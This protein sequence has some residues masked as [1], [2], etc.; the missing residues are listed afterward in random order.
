MFKSIRSLFT[1]PV[2]EDDEDKTRVAYLL[3]ALLISLITGLILIGFITGF[4]RLTNYVLSLFITI[5][6]WSVMRSGHIRFASITIVAGLSILLTIVI[7]LTGGIRASTYGGFI[8]VIL[9]AG[10]VLGERSSI[11]VASFAS[12]LGGVLIG[13]ASYGIWEI[14]KS[15]AS[16]LTYWIVYTFYFFVS[17]V[18]LILASRLI[19]NSYRKIRVELI[20][21][22][23][24]E[25]EL[26]ILYDIAT[27]STSVDSL[28]EL[29]KQISNKIDRYINTDLFSVWL[30]DK[31]SQVL[32]VVSRYYHGSIPDW[33]PPSIPLRTGIIGIVASTG[34]AMRIP[35]VTKEP[36]YLDAYSEARSELCVPMCI[37]ERV[38]GVINMES[39]TLNA[40][41]EDNERLLVTIASQL[42]IATERFRTEEILKISEERLQQAVR[43]SNIGIFDHDHL[44]DTIYWS[45][46]QRRNYGWDDPEE[47]VVLDKFFNQ[48]Y[49][50]DRERIIT[51]VQKAHDPDGDGYFDVEHRITRKDGETRWLSTKS[52]TH[53]DG[54]GTD[55]HPYRTI[56]AVIDITENKKIE[57]EREMFIKELEDRNTD[58]ERF[59]YTV[60]HE[61]KSPIVTMKG[62]IGSVDSDLQHGN[63]ERAKKDLTRVS[64]AVDKMN[65]TLSG[66]LELTRI[67]HVVNPLTVISLSGLVESVLESI[68]EQI[69]SPDV[70]V[71]VNLDLPTIIGD[72]PRLQKVYENLIINAAKNMGN[73]TAPRIEIGFRQDD[74]ITVF[75]VKDNGVGID[76]RYHTKVFG[77]FDKLESQGEGTG[78]GLAIVKRIIETYDGKIWV[79]SDGLGKGSVF[80]FT[81]PSSSQ[82][83]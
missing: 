21:R 19:G 18:V 4:D 74:N 50:E 68:P 36:S 46:E 10:L 9:L 52:R 8:V 43:A 37:G 66:L 58:L 57:T 54:T 34:R 17:A 82:T 14:P 13:V 70:H 2:F 67:G 15:T 78:V 53:F 22:K 69:L 55:R 73:Q 38:I 59:N 49:P 16:D 77:L 75:F 44:S 72:K 56:G 62:F 3:N 71:E 7:P 83:Q 32:N 47:I 64:A 80:C 51:A 60:S 76:P 26:T 24:A 20:E 45:L 31:H 81:I 12:L 25:D 65:Q 63:Y 23:R 35:D 39:D 11:I 40:F 6:A 61:L 30:L 29:F 28:A 1:P 42:A 48:V 41:S 5:T 27:L 79:E 33:T